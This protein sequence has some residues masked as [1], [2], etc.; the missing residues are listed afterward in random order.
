MFAYYAYALHP[1]LVILLVLLLVGLLPTWPYSRQWGYPPVGLL[2]LVVILILLF[3]CSAKAGEPVTTT[4]S[5]AWFK[6]ESLLQTIFAAHAVSVAVYP[7]YDPYIT[8]GGVKKPYGFGLSV[9]YPINEYT[10]AGGRIDFL[11]NTFWAPSAVVGAK[12]T[13]K[14]LPLQPTVFTVAGLIMPL[15]GAG[16]ENRVVGAITGMGATVTLWQSK[17]GNFTVNAFIEGEKWTNFEGAIIHPG[18]AG[19]LKF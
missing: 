15:G 19:G 9:L 18:I 7:S 14:N 13:L 1:L 11:G 10:F 6:D 2:L 3:G 16:T 17:D 5:P 8:V 4:T 12:Y